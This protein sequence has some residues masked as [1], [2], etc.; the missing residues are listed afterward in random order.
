MTDPQP[1]LARVIPRMTL[2]GAEL[3]AVLLLEGLPG[4]RCVVTHLDGE[5]GPRARAASDYRVLDEPTLAPLVQALEGV[6]SVHLHL[7][8]NHPLLPLAAVLAGPR[9]LVTTVHNAFPSKWGHLVDHT[10]LLGED[11][12]ALQDTARETT[13]VHD[14]VESLDRLPERSPWTPSC[15]RPLRLVAIR[16]AD[17]DM[18]WT[19]ADLLATGVFDDWEVEATVLGVTGRSDEARLTYAGPCHDVPE[20]LAQADW[21]VH[22]SAAESFGRV[23]YEALAHGAEVACTP[24]PALRAAFGPDEVTFL[25]LDSPR[26]AA[27]RL[28]AAIEAAAADP[29]ATDVRRERNRRRMERDFGLDAYVANTA[30]VYEA[31]AAGPR[32]RAFRA[33]DVPRACRP[34]L[35][36]LVDPWLQ[37]GEPPPPREVLALPDPAAALVLWMVAHVSL[38]DPEARLAWLA[39]AHQLVGPRS[40]VALGLG[41]ALAELGRPAKALPWFVAAAERRPSSTLAWCGALDALIALQRIGE[42]RALLDHAQRFAGPHPTLRPYHGLSRPAPALTETA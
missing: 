17:K 37:T 41:Q 18:V 29:G 38:A 22:G 6:P 11:S 34:R 35:F 1:A 3:D 14:G 12:R 32:R 30:A 33:A 4:S 10:I 2:G 24:L 42:A 21:L 26:R 31:V 15:G 23:V 39:R 27:E 16:R 8:N 9:T 19:L 7:L 20:R 13:L 40:A 25:P 36:D 28:R 5:L